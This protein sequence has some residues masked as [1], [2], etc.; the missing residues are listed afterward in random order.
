MFCY[1]YVDFISYYGIAVQWKHT[2]H[3]PREPCVHELEIYTILLFSHL[4]ILGPERSF[5][6][7]HFIYELPNTLQRVLGVLQ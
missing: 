6:F 3:L 5:T 7:S 2:E 4:P 1:V